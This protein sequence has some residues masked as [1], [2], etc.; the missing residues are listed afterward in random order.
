MQ[1]LTTEDIPRP[2]RLGFVHDFIGR[3]IGG[4]NFN[5]RDRDEVRIDLEAMQLPGGLT[6]G[7]GRFSPLHGART[8][9]LLQDGRSHYLLTIHYEDYEVSADGKAPIKVAA[10]DVTVMD[11]SV[12]SEFRFGRTMA[13]DAVALDRGLIAG[14]VPRLGSEAVYVLPGMAPDMR[15]LT[16][17]LHTV[18]A[19]LPASEKAREL[20]SRHIHDLAALVLDGAVNGGAERNER[21][22]AAARLKVAQKDILERLSDHGLHVDAVARRQ[23]VTARYIQRLFEI[24][25][26]TFSDFVRDR[27]LDLALRLLKERE[28]A[29]SITDIAYDAGFSDISS[30]NRAFRRRFGA[31]PSE[32]RATN[33]I[34]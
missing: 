5:P 7:R 21:S 34:L 10:G 31:T 16:S 17:Y 8:R 4:M 22:I 28:R 23:G 24:E 3:H 27:R 6:V 18:R 12:C 32:I 14:L 25:G 26:M 2:E 29:S 30:F 11:E 19:W 15:L 33:L 9:N 20:A 1:R 13:V